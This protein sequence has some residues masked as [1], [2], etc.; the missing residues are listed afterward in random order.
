M[1]TDPRLAELKAEVDRLS[2]ALEA[3]RLE[4]VRHMLSVGT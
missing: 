2:L 4:L 3:A 1:S